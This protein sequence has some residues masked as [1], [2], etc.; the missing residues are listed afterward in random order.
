MK[1]DLVPSDLGD[2]AVFRDLRGEDDRVRLVPGAELPLEVILGV[3]AEV[4]LSY[5]SAETG[6]VLGRG[7]RE[8]V[9][10]TKIVKTCS[11]KELKAHYYVLTIT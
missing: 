1:C 11:A 5:L 2:V 10:K 6:Q 9:A 8:T 4:I 7:M 3:T